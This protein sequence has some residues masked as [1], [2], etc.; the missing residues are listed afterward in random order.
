MGLARLNSDLILL[1]WRAITK[2][3]NRKKISRDGEKKCTVLLHT[4][5]LITRN[6][7]TRHSSVKLVN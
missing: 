4:L 1:E 7:Q 2:D 5:E 3:G 6:G